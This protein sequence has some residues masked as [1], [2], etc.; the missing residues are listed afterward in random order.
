MLSGKCR[1]RTTTGYCCVF[2]F[3]Y[4]RRRYNRCI[5]TRRHGRPWCP[6]TPDYPRSRHWGYCRGGRGTC[7]CYLFL[8][9]LFLFSYKFFVLHFFNICTPVIELFKIQ[10]KKKKK[11]ILVWRQYTL[12]YGGA[13]KN[14]TLSTL[15][16]WV[17]YSLKNGTLS[18]SFQ[19]A[20]NEVHR[21]R[22][23]NVISSQ[24]RDLLRFF[25]CI[26]VNSASNTDIWHNQLFPHQIKNIVVMLCIQTI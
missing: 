21:F 22:T 2:P 4:R 11:K 14:E 3:T 15:F 6:I 5:R 16:H 20:Y 9:Y 10:Y 26:F 1:L 25:T 8:Y 12:S 23:R 18:N 13:L 24:P 19:W 7:F 17:T